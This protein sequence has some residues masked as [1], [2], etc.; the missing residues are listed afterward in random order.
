[1]YVLNKY[2]QWLYKIYICKFI[3]LNNGYPID[4]RT[5]FDANHRKGLLELPPDAVPN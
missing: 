5:L 1:M 2:R 3:L 4:D